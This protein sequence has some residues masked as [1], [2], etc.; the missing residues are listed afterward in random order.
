MGAKTA[1]YTPHA[2]DAGKCLRATA[3]YTDGKG[4]TD[5]MGVSANAVIADEANR[6][7]RF[8]AG[9]VDSDAG[10]MADTGDTATSAKRSI[11]ENVT[12]TA[13]PNPADVGMPVVAD[14]PNGD[15]LTYTL[16]GN[17]A[18]SFKIGPA[19]G[20][21]SAKMKLDKEAKSSHMV[22]V[23]A[24]DPN[25]ANA[26]I[27]VT[28]SVTNVDEPPKIIAGGLAI[29]GP[30][31]ASYAENGTGMVATYTLAGPEKD[32]G[33]WTLS[34]DDARDF[35]ISNSGV[36]SFRSSPNYE[37]PA[38]EDMDNVYMVTLNATD[39]ERNEATRDVV[40]T[41]TDVDDEE[42]IGGTLLERYDTGDE[43]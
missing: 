23:T 42:V 41:V 21:I 18:G 7:P 17:D 39:S 37:A 35:S 30:S 14:D 32:S 15:T 12:P 11:D 31:S 36:L 10:T 6:P 1:T 20:Q 28:I 9:G 24:T 13:D 4:S 26:S 2:K 16:S 40:V 33:R 5:A 34:G 3:E 19:S 8:R 27:D 29:S 43:R 22:T 25:G 38:D